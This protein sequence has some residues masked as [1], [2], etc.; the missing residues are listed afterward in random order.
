MKY[1]GKDCHFQAKRARQIEIRKQRKAGLYP[2][3]NHKP[4]ECLFC[5][6]IFTPRKESH[7]YCTPSC[8]KKRLRLIYSE[9]KIQRIR[10]RKGSPEEF[11]KK[12]CEKYNIVIEGMM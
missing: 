4:R 2:A 8:S 6:K 10:V 3:I 1:C 7:K 5:K 9:K 11:K 12:L